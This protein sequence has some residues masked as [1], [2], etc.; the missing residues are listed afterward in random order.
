MELFVHR[1]GRHGIQR[2]TSSV[3]DK[4][5]A[6]YLTIT[7][8][9]FSLSFFGLFAIRPTLITGISLVQS[10]NELKK[11][12]VQYENKISAIIRAQS[13]YE[14]IRDSIPFVHAAIP[15]DAA[16]HHLATG[17]E[18]FAT[19][20]NVTLAQLQIDSVPVSQDL[21]GK[22]LKQYGFQLIASGGYED[23]FTYL[24]HL[25]NWKRI[26]TLKSLEMNQEGSTSSGQIRL[27]V[28]GD[29]YYEP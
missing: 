3:K 5:A 14:K 18:M 7:L 25:T 8:T 24:S 19:R 17:L 28:K 16:F 1:F 22:G 23:L 27:S 15:N 29:A 4:K 6:S 13:E 12:N 21:G 10:V 20:S 9:L 26:I 2:L 11:L